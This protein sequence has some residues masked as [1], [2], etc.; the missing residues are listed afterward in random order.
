MAGGR[1]LPS[2][3]SKESH[4]FNRGRMSITNGEK[5]S[6]GR[7][8]SSKVNDGVIRDVARKGE[9]KTHHNKYVKR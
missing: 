5:R 6:F 8:F 3:G 2:A 1:H 7:Y 9:G 4:G